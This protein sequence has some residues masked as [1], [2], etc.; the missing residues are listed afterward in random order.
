MRGL[1][2]ASAALL[3]LVPLLGADCSGDEEVVY[4]QL[5]NTAD[6]VP[7]EVGV[8]DELDDAVAELLSNTGSEVVGSVT[9]SPG[10][11]PIGTLHSVTV[12]VGDTLVDRVDLVRV[13][14]TAD[15]RDD[16]VV[17]LVQDSANEGLWFI[18]L[19]SFGAEDETRT[20]EFEVQLL[21]D[22]A[23]ESSAADDDSGG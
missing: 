12:E 15:G 23:S 18:Q 14:A 10:G 19:Q 17:D 1:P 7:V 11:G 8:P 16:R 5:N 20:D 3:L 22:P 13:N 2:R 9:V 21:E 4:D 6:A